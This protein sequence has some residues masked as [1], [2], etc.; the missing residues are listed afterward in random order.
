MRG[1]ILSKEYAW[2]FVITIE[3][4]EQLIDGVLAHA[5]KLRSVPSPKEVAKDEDRVVL[6][7]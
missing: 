4:F 2:I 6:E 7:R 3:I 1:F 5:H